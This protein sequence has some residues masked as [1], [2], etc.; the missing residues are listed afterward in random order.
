MEILKQR[1][2]RLDFEERSLV[3]MFVV[4]LARGLFSIMLTA[5]L[6]V[7]YSLVYG[8]EPWI[9]QFISSIYFFGSMG[10]PGI[11]FIS[12]KFS[13]M[14]YRRK[15]FALSGTALLMVSI[16]VIALVEPVGV[17][18]MGSLAVAL[19]FY[20]CGDSF[21]DVAFDSWLIDISWNN[22]ALKNKGRILMRTGAICGILLGMLSG[23]ICINRFWWMFMLVIFLSVF[24]SWMLS[25]WIPK[26]TGVNVM[27]LNDNNC[28]DLSMENTGKFRRRTKNPA[29]RSKLRLIIVIFMFVAFMPEPMVNII[30]EPCIIEHLNATPQNFFIVELLG[31]AIGLALILILLAIIRHSKSDMKSVFTIMLACQSFYYF[32]LVFLTPNLAI[33]AIWTMMKVAIGAIGVMIMDRLLMDLV[34]GKYAATQFQMFSII[35]FASMGVASIIGALISMKIGTTGT[36]FFTFVLCSAIT[37]TFEFIIKKQFK[38]LATNTR[39]QTNNE[40]I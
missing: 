37:I 9:V 33:Y 1:M 39:T 29:F 17:V 22:P 38:L 21:T 15:V 8:I 11:A 3:T 12:D 24:I 5:F 16:L 34:N 19:V 36:I 6:A 40:N 4:K 18:G 14:G 32:A 2:L 31:N 26:A 13:F 25:L 20:T 7:H 27:R 35:I 10:R 23:T 30:Q 28:N